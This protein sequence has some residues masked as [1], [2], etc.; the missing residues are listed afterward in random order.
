MA[1]RGSVVIDVVAAGCNFFDALQVAGKYQDKPRLPYVPGSE[2]AGVVRELGEGVTELAVG[3]RVMAGLIYGAFAERVAVPAARVRKIPDSMSFETAAAVPIVYPTAY[4][5][6]DDRASLRA[7]ESVLVTAAAG[8]IGLAA[9][10]IAK[11]LGARVIAATGSE[12]KGRIARAAGADAAV[13]YDGA[14]WPS[15][16]AV[17]N[18]GKPVDV[19]IDCVGGEVFEGAWK[20]VAWSGR[21]VVVGFASGTIPSLALN[22][23]LL[24]NASVTGIFLGT[25]LEKRPA[26]LRAAEDSV[27]D[28]YRERRISPRVSATFPL[29]QVGRA[30]EEVASRRSTGKVVITMEP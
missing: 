18:G 29:A 21:L 16:V 8:G 4:V 20:C 12:E 15:L 6:L 7:G 14:D 10:E 13:T 22:R 17:A 9:V 28:L 24:K 30:L 19:V 5:A 1:K 3:D 23:V 2:C 25:Y 11:A 26:V 27:L